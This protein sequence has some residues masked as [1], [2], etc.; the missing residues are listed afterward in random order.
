MGNEFFAMPE[1]H[2]SFFGLLP[3]TVYQKLGEVGT[4]LTKLMKYS[5]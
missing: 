4:D 3:F 1:D 5:A 2:T